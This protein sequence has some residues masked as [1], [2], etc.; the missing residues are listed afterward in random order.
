MM[1]GLH[2]IKDEHAEKSLFRSRAMIA[3]I[4]IFLA[5]AILAARF[6][7]LQVWKYGSF[8][9]QADKNRIRLQT[10][11]PSRGMIYDRNGVLL[12]ENKPA[13]RLEITTERLAR[14]KIDGKRISL[15]QSRD[16][17]LSELEK[18][19]TITPTQRKRFLRK[20]Q[21]SKSFR[22]VPLRLSLNEEELSRVAVNRHRLPGVEITPYLTRHYPG[23]KAMTHLTGYVG[24]IDEGD[25]AG[26]DQENYH[27]NT[28]IGKTGVERY[29]EDIL[30][31]ISGFEKVETNAQGRVLR[32]LER[33]D[34][35]AGQDLILAID[36]RLQLAA[37]DAM[38]DY[39]GSVIALDPNNGD[40]LAMVSKPGFDANLFVN[41]ITQSDYSRILN[42]PD[43]PLYNRALKGGYEPGSTFKPFVALAGLEGGTVNLETRVFSSGEFYLPNVSRPYRDWRPGGHGWV[44]V[45][46]ALQQSV[47]TYFYELGVKL[48][49]DAM[50]DYIQ[51]FG[52]GRQTGIDLFGEGVGVLPSRA[53]KRTRFDQ[54]WYPGETVIAAIGQGYNVTTPLQLASATATLAMNGKR[55]IPRLV[56]GFKKY[57]SQE[58]DWLLPT[59]DTPVP[60]VNPLNWAEVRGGMEDVVNSPTGTARKISVG[61]AYRIAGKSGT[62]QVFQLAKGQKYDASAIDRRLR[63]NALFVAWAPAEAPKIVV[64]III[65]HAL[66]GGS[67][68]AAPIARILLDTWLI[69]AG[70][71]EDES[72]APPLQNQQAGR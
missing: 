17:T 7:Y 27:A 54:P 69:E 65:E 57:G 13:Y 72:L 22:P 67:S 53:W 28:H 21:Q 49:I 9:V 3:F 61:A 51:Q 35:E 56:R 48:G 33:E 29:R 55:Y 18:L 70:H 44:T 52:F 66:G 68:T 37:W 63:N 15:A 41:G 6:T 12:A 23:G 24:R 19:V 16:D 60:V 64:A 34:P 36:S 38:G 14:P 62:A 25:L 10:V 20:S 11:A 5:L 40:V 59:L 43:R 47:N 71:L 30:H 46:S 42:A 2:H 32:V 8:Q 50:H 39:S 45:R 31:G 26:L 4:L 1:R 58:V